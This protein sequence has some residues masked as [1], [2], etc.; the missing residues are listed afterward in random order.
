M[1]NRIRFWN[2]RRRLESELDQELECHR[3]MRQ[4]QL[5]QS[6]MSAT[7]AASV[8]RRAMGNTTLAREDARALWTWP[9]LETFLR[10][11][12]YGCR[13][14]IR[15]RRFSSV[16]LLT[17]A[18]GIG[19]NTA[20]FSAVEA[21]ILRPLPYP[22]PDR[23]VMLWTDDVKQGAHEEPTSFL[24][25]QDW[26]AESRQ[27]ADMAFFRGEPSVILSGDAPDRVLAESASANLFPLI[28][29]APALGRT[30]TQDEQDRGEPVVVLSHGLWQR[31]FGAR[32]DAIGQT[33]SLDARTSIVRLRVIGV[34]PAG[35]AFPSRDAQFW[36]PTAVSERERTQDRFRFV[37]R[38]YGAVGRL[39]P[40]V[41][42]GQAQ[43]EMTVIGRRLAAAHPTSDQA[44]P[45]FGVSVV[46]LLDHVAGRTIQSALWMLL[47]A[48]GVVLLM[49]CVN[50]A[51]LL[52]ARG[53]AR[54][55]ELAI[56]TS[57][58]AGRSRL[59]RQLLTET[60]ILTLVAAI[61]GL[62]LAS[63]GLRVLTALAPVGI[64]PESGSS[65][66]LT[67]SVPVIARSAQAGIPRLD[68]VSVDATVL[69]FTV[70]LSFLSTLVFGLFPAFKM[71]Q[72]DP[73]ESLKQGAG[74]GIGGRALRR[75]G[76]SLIVVEC[77]LAV[78]LLA[79]AG[80]LIRS[81]VRLQSVDP[82][83]RANG[84]LLGRVSLAPVAQRSSSR[85][86]E[87]NPRRIF[88]SHVF[89]RI[90]AIPTVQ[91]VGLITDLL[92]RGRAEGSIKVADRSPVPTGELAFGH[93]SPGFFETLN[94]P[95]RQ[96]R[97]LSDADTLAKL[98]LSELT[99]DEMERK[100]L[101]QAVDVNESFARRFLAD[102]NPIG[103]RFSIARDRFEVVG[104][105]GDMRRDGP[106]HPAIP[107][108]FSPYVGQTSELAVR[109]SGDPTAIAT[110]V[111][112]AIRSV[113]KNAMV[114]SVT[115]LERRLG[116]LTAPRQAQTWLLASFAALAL[117]L[118]MVGIH[119]I[120]RYAVSQRHHEIALRI[121]LGARP[122]DVVRLIVGHGM[123]P[124]LA[125]VAIGLVCAMWLTTVMAHLVFEISPTDPITFTGVAIVLMTVA[126]VACWLPARRAARVDPI[127][128]LR[129][130]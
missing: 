78:L 38:R 1:R 37:G 43:G 30:F 115:T 103:A 32:Q 72:A 88:Y 49:A 27:V 117:M 48:G 83:F 40:G 5:E 26:R 65:Y 102:V 33:M 51:S 66:V 10:D 94:V 98:R 7:E 35:F 120:V 104:V 50:A 123:V 13:V 19:A 46:P 110:A 101:T 119:G 87:D 128:A 41:T 64:Y 15:N 18:L 73:N 6:G 42:V 63:A 16:A 127:V 71:S 47:A 124:P 116:E 34:M 93:V 17:L 28:G 106:E 89:D 29:V 56:R 23:L 21:V 111:R 90:R 12:K 58:G 8:S 95:L 31:R 80:L 81:F 61:F 36:M 62:M 69:A 97:F 67:D 24:T 59:L 114:L 53:A 125:G 60:A 57:L 52:L 96:G 84:V 108:F 122:S 86:A 2:D 129:S 118:A 121:A 3:A 105:V 113:D 45:G 77:A 112:Q 55:R 79:G 11:A 74:V 92:V 85:A 20:I 39:R 14:L 130:E 70:A 109:A 91:S 54:A 126:W 9:S 4:E 25:I 68:E 44:F 22:D 76:N 75:A 82:G 100:D 107:E 99:A